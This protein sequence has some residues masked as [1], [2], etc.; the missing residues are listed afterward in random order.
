MRSV[1]DTKRCVSPTLEANSNDASSHALHNQQP[2]KFNYCTEKDEK[3]FKHKNIFH[4]LQ[5]PI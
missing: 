1:D 3:H 4:L 5:D 2:V